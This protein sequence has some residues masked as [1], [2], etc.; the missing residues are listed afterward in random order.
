MSANTDTI[1]QLS[2]EY[3]QWEQDR[4]ALFERE[5]AGELSLFDE[6]L[7]DSDDGGIDLL[8]RLAAALLPDVDAE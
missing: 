6:S 4:K 2:A 5:E 8:Y 7:G 3:R 1:A